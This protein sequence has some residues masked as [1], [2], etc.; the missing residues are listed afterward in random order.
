MTRVVNGRL[1][2]AEQGFLRVCLGRQSCVLRQACSWVTVREFHVRSPTDQAATAYDAPQSRNVG[3]IELTTPLRQG[4][5][6]L[7]AE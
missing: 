3:L 7:A 4:A 5:A 2:A 1:S 6:Q